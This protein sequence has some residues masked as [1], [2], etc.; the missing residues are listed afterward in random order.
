M[1]HIIFTREDN[2]FSDILRD[3]TLKKLIT[4]TLF[5]D[6]HLHIGLVENTEAILSYIELKYGES[7]ASDV[8]KDFT[9]VPWVHYRPK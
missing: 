1:K 4:I 6:N 2:D 5:W 9:P 8:Y 7:I 3:P